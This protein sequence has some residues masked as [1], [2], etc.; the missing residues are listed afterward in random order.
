MLFELLAFS[1]AI[2]ILFH[3][4][5]HF[6]MIAPTGEFNSVVSEVFGHARH[7]FQW[8]VSPLTGK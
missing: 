7:L 3:S 8:Q 6:E 1:G 2:A 4:A 5:F